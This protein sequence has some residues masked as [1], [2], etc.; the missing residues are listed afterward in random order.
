MKAQFFF[1]LTQN[2]MENSFVVLHL[3]HLP[4]YPCHGDQF[5]IRKN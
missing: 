5:S 4:V 1:Y 3:L 2:A